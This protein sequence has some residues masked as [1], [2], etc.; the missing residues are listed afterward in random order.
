MEVIQCALLNQ[1]RILEQCIHNFLSYYQSNVML[2]EKWYHRSA[3]VLEAKKLLLRL[4]YLIDRI[5]RKLLTIQLCKS[6]NSLVGNFYQYGRPVPDLIV[7][8]LLI[9]FKGSITKNMWLLKIVFLRLYRIDQL[10]FWLH[11]FQ[12]LVCL[13]CHVHLKLT[14]AN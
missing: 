1:N 11:I 14:L 4:F 3:S 6:F 10:Q 5:I 7:I 2:L 12:W 13:L 8:D 9:S